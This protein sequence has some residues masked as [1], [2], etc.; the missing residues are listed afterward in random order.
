MNK[1]QQEIE[2]RAMQLTRQHLRDIRYIAAQ[3]FA[4]CLEYLA[5]ETFQYVP[6][7]LAEMIEKT[8]DEFKPKIRR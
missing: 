3:E 6:D 8:L 4:S 2:K 7:Y 5:T 1:K